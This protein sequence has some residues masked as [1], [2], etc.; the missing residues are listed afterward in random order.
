MADQRARRLKR[1]LEFEGTIQAEARIVIERLRTG[2]IQAERAWLAGYLG[3]GPAALALRVVPFAVG[4]QV[5]DLDEWLRGFA[6]GGREAWVRAALA[7]TR[8]ARDELGRVGRAPPR[9][10]RAA[11]EAGCAWAECP[12]PDHQE[13]VT[14]LADWDRS[15]PEGADAAAMAQ[16]A[17]EAALRA[18]VEPDPARQALRSLDQA[19]SAVTRVNEVVRD[20]R[21]ER[22][23]RDGRRVFSWPVWQRLGTI[24][25]AVR[26]ELIP[27]L[28]AERDPVAE[29]RSRRPC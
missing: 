7:A 28:L 26:E 5:G 6:P 21:L 14:G 16:R 2:E 17:A 19:H 23:R 13:Q 22:K 8:C 3:H 9:P 24:V 27:W 25:D 4:N 29:G 12:C 15:S 11:F 10:L 20:R 18:I 1:E